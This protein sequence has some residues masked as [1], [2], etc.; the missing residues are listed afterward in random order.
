MVTPSSD[1][2]NQ[3][4]RDTCICY[5]KNSPSYANVHPKSQT[6]KMAKGKQDRL[7]DK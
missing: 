1:Q 6:A 4:F 3:N 2:L 7:V 5:F